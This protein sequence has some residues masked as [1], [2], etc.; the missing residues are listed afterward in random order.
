M[1]N[2]APIPVLVVDDGELQD[3]RE[4][5]AGLDVPHAEA[6]S[7]DAAAMPPGLSLLV[8]SARHALDSG[9][10]EP[11]SFLHL[12]VYDDPSPALHKAVHRSGCDLVLQRPV[13]RHTFR[14][15]VSQALY[16]GPERRVGRRVV[17]SAPVELRVDGRTRPATLIQL[18]LRGC[19]LSTHESVK[20]GSEIQ[21]GLPRELTGGEP[22]RASGPVL[23]V[24]ELKPGSGPFEVALAFRL[25]D[26]PKR[27]VLSDIM[28][29]HGSGA[30][31]RPRR[32][33]Q[34]APEPAAA[35]T[36][37]GVDD[38]RRDGPRKSFNRRVLAAGAG[39]SHML[40]GRDLSSGGMR[41]R[42][43]PDLELGD[44]IKLAVYGQP[45]QPAIMLKAVV[46]RDEGED[47]LVLR[48]RDVSTSIAARLERIVAELP[49]LPMEDPAASSAQP[50][51][52]VSEILERR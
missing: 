17:L 25:M 27:R 35:S 16:Q 20:I 41:V 10:L 21:L 43:E 28:E 36:H 40:I 29:R 13:N 34:P 19:G 4:M 37:P 18:S 46:I 52:V 38:E 23:S 6:R 51:V 26:A 48:F 47:G 45:G 7:T 39:I 1:S 9:A 3:I 32:A 12:V 24:R 49:T 33:A 50:G 15:L 8:T 11:R 44:E 5:L 2:A 30:E 22:L 42:P 14:L 31:L